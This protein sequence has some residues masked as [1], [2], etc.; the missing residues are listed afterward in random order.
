[1]MDTMQEEKITLEEAI[2]VGTI[3]C[4]VRDVLRRWYLIITV[5]LVAAMAAFIY[6]DL[7]YTPQYTATATLVVSGGTTFTTTYQNLTAA[8][9]TATVFTEIL[10][11][12]LLRQKVTEETG[13]T[14]FDGTITAGVMGGTNL[15]NV[16]VRGSDAR[17]VFLVTRSLIDNH[18]VVSA[19]VLGNIVLE[20]LQE[21]VVPAGPSNAKNTGLIR[22]ALVLGAAVTAGLLGLDAWMSDRLRSRGEADKK[23]TCRVLGELYHE[24]KRRRLRDLLTGRKSGI[25]ITNP[26][27]S[28][29][30]SESIHKLSSR[31]DK[32][33]R[34]G[35]RVVMVTSL[36][37]N[38]GKST[39]AVNL[40]LSWAAK[41]R[42]VLLMDCDLRK[43]AC[44][45]ILDLT[46]NGGMQKLLQ[47][48]GTMDELTLTVP[49]STLHLLS[50]GKGVRNASALLTSAAMER[51]LREAAAR[52]DLVI[53]DT[54]PMGMT[55]DAE[56]ISEL[57]NCALVVARQNA[58]E[59]GAL[60]EAV[61]ALEKTGTHM[62][63]CVLNNVYGAGGFAPVFHGGVY[64]YGRYGRY[65]KYNK[66]GY[67]KYGYGYGYGY[68]K[69]KRSADDG[70][71]GA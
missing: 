16:T 25:L 14:D 65:G 28:F 35:E 64:G 7:S 42:Q 30:Y 37:E 15:L 18:S 47:G 1:M 38:E 68:G 56:C 46:D 24:R 55:P 17:S 11:S 63:G 12:S 23:L 2:P 36:L 60:N 67:Y 45:K 29:L 21:P 20:V 33:R 51:L 26:L 31:I 8:N 71:K 66:Y 59:A 53:V 9:E 41:G 54:P 50:G 13:I 70:E 48:E 62:L 58:A 5:A 61:Q 32:L 52:Y 10:N 27:I 43:P 44:H 22:L 19:E 40:A 39:V 4:V 57:T 3:L 34:K 49:D 6:A 69:K